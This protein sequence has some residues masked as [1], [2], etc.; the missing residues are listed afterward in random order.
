MLY[1]LLP[2]FDDLAYLG[3]LN[4]TR[5][6]TFRT[7][8]A[9]L[10]A[11][12][13]SLLLGPWMIRKLRDFQIG[14]I[15][16]QE[17]PQSHRA[18]AGTPTMGGL[19]ILSSALIPTLLWA[20]LLNPYIWIAVLATAGFGAVGFMDD[21]LKI[22]RRSH[23][24]LIPRYK[25]G[26]QLVIALGVGLAVLYLAQQNPPL[27]NTRLIFPFFK[28]LIPD[29]GLMYLPFAVFIL[30]AW[31][32]AVNLT[33]GLD[34]LAISTFGVAAAA[35]TALAY[36]TGHAQLADY[37]D[38]VRFPPAGELTIFCGALVGASLGFLW[39]NSYPAE[40]FMGDVG[41][42]ALGGALATVSV[43]IKQE[44]LLVIVG[45]VFV[46]EAA[47][48]VIQVASFK[49][50]GKRVFKMS[51]LH[52]HFELIGWSEPKIIAR[53]LIMAIIFGL[54]SLTTLKLR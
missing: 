29:L 21:Y 26:G 51:P 41:S 53:F 36:V 47:S 12:A 43:L 22:V 37:L 17:G 27:Y 42:L 48:V 49:L 38:L 52:H 31:S 6:I 34:G 5:Y 18:K 3:V 50:T 9:S 14:Q 23:H 15:I 46:M 10:T 25:M 13:I 30:V 16:R 24:G 35:F 20:D 33:D 40:I 39:Y 11:L 45:G 2:R 44:L 7:A 19:L 8:A 28:N 54:F 1:H 32:N 4:V